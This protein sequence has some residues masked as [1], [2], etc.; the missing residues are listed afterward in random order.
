MLCTYFNKP[1]SPHELNQEIPFALSSI[2]MKLLAKSPDERYQSIYGLKNDLA[3]CCQQWREAGKIELFTLGQA[4]IPHRLQFQSKLFGREEETAVL[5]DAFNK[6]CQGSIESVIISG[7]PGIGKTAL[8]Q[9]FAKY[10]ASGQGQFICGC[11]RQFQ[12][13]IPYIGIIQAIQDLIRQI[14]AE[15]KQKIKRWGNRIQQVLGINGGIMTDII[16]EL[17]LISGEFPSVREIPP[18]ES[19]NRFSSI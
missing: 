17:K 3:R 2:I 10:I 19:E 11:Y 1:K 8:V 9:E 18:R 7:Y 14:L 16:P 12:E 13:D 15:P 4:D 5:I 6:V